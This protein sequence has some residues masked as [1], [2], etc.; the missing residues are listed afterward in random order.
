MSFHEGISRN[1]RHLISSVARQTGR[2]SAMH[3]C[4]HRSPAGI[5]MP[6]LVHAFGK[7]RL[8][9]RPTCLV[10]PIRLNDYGPPAVHA[11][12]IPGNNYG[13]YCPRTGGMH[14]GPRRPQVR[15]SFR[16]GGNGFGEAAVELAVVRAASSVAVSI[17]ISPSPLGLKITGFATSGKVAV[18][19]LRTANW[20]D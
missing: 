1:R 13:K 4:D 9:V 18:S 20:D 12:R 15:P 5:E 11:L 8:G 7:S 3:Y 10:L 17:W 2:R 14:R 16:A 6:S 19:P